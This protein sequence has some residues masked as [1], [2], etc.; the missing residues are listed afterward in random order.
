MGFSD[1]SDFGTLIEYGAGL[2]WS[3]LEGVTFSASLIG[4]ENA[5]GLGQLGN[6]TIVTPNVAYYD[7]ARGESRFIDVVTAS[8]PPEADE[9][10]Y[11]KTGGIDGDKVED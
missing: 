1:L 10:R 5:P 4:D 6:P 9:G 8:R 2:R 7:F 3:P 11:S